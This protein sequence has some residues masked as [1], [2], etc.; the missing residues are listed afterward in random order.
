MEKVEFLEI[1]DLLER[2][3]SYLLEFHK[4]NNKEISRLS[5]GCIRNLENFYYSRE[6]LLNA[7]GRLDS[8]CNYE[9]FSKRCKV[10]FKEKEKLSH[11]FKLKDDMV[12][13]IL[14]Q[15]VVILSLVDKLHEGKLPIAS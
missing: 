3:N 14:D 7:I 1:L 8:R 5:K 9:E 13:S 15:D 2:K 11:I 12:R 6:L 4:I 10:N